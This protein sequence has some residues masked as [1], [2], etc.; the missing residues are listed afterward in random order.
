MENL[1][2][3]KTLPDKDIVYAL[4][5]SLGVSELVASLLAQRGIETFEEAKQFFRPQ[6][7]D[8]YN[9]F[10]MKDMDKAVERLHRAITS[11]EKILVY[12][13]YDVDGTTA[14]SLMYLFL[15]EKS[16]YVEYY[17]PDRY[18]EG[19]GISYKGIDLSLIHI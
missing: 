10:L 7:S 15:K 16:K 2:T 14:V 19:Y 18:D 13:D 1:W 17:I 12:G 8:L 6:L 3:L 5:E 9:P 4:K 11:N